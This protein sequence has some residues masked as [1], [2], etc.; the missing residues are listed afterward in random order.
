MN[1]ETYTIVLTEWQLRHIL[2]LATLYGEGAKNTALIELIENRLH[3]GSD[4]PV[5]RDGRPMTFRGVSIE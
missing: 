1:N 4:T 3:H 5:A 2:A